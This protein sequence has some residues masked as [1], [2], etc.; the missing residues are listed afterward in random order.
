MGRREATG[1]IPGGCPAA[2][3][4]GRG[5]SPGLLCG[6]SGLVHSGWQG[7]WVG[8][9]AGRGSRAPAPPG[10]K[11]QCVSVLG[12]L[13]GPGA[14]SAHGPGL[15]LRAAGHAVRGAGVEV[16]PLRA[17]PGPR[18]AQRPHLRGG[19]GAPGRFPEVL[20]GSRR[21]PLGASVR[22]HDASPVQGHQTKQN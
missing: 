9:W 11:V 6:V 19:Q 22:T 17:P 7:P 3:G 16:R 20:G 12:E 18:G 10:A 15:R 21:F 13:C 2:R 1:P 4:G 5:P 8:R 14:V